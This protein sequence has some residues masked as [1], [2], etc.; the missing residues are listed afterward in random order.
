VVGIAITGERAQ[1]FAAAV[2]CRLRRNGA[3]PLMG[4]YPKSDSAVEPAAPRQ[5]RGG[6]LV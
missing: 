2:A 1:A 4:R 5:S 6:R 3:Q